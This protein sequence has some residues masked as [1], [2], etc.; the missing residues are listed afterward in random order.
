M[1]ID[2]AAL[3][4]ESV[5]VVLNHLI[6][7]VSKTEE[8][9]QE[10][11]EKKKQKTTDLKLFI[12]RKEGFELG[13][14]EEQLHSLAT[15]DSTHKFTTDFIDDH[16]FN[17]EKLSE[18]ISLF[19][20]RTPSF[21]RRDHAIL[22]DTDRYL[23]VYSTERR[24]WTKKTIE[25]VIDYLP[26]L[27]RLYLSADDIQSIVNDLDEVTETHVSGFTS[28]YQSFDDER[29]ISIQFHGGDEND[30][31][32]IKEEFNAKPTRVEFRQKNSPT[33][34][35]T[36]AV[37]RNA[38]INIP[39]VRAGSEDLGVNTLSS[40]AESFEEL[41]SEH[42]N[43][44]NSPKMSLSAGGIEI[45]GFT[46]I[47]LHDRGEEQEAIA[48]GGLRNQSEDERETAFISGLK[49]EILEKKQRYDFSRWDDGE[50][51]VL[52]KERTETFH[53]GVCNN[54]L[55]IN[56]RPETTPITVKEFTRIIL[57][58]FR[59]TYEIDSHSTDLAGS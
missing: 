54:D 27:S 32:H 38:R 9:L 45:D 34:A 18:D 40:V 48:D 28:K 6:D 17:E 4:G 21:N 2:T 47:R 50:F 33:D 42:F 39:G 19:E 10:E 26:G 37:T 44:P 8:E 59:S 7:Y 15:S 5:S 53:L 58:E 49:E 1:D 3:K 16:G 29:R 20:V 46:T 13:S 35:V 23:R 12:A 14:I 11:K 24:H 51:L 55:V 56:A 30:I 52:D 36:G 25:R 57:E 43:I 41:D 31:Q 22:I